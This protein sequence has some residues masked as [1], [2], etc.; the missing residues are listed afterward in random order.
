MKKNFKVLTEIEELGLTKEELLKYYKGLKKSFYLSMQSG[1]N[2]VKSK[3]EE[4][5]KNIDFK[6]IKE[7]IYEKENRCLG[8]LNRLYTSLTLSREEL[9]DFYENTRK[10]D[11]LTDRPIPLIRFTKT[12]H[13]II[14]GTLIVWR[15]LNNQKLEIINK[16]EK[17][18]IDKDPVIYV[19]THVGGKYDVSMF[20]E[21]IKSPYVLFAGDPEVMYRTF[22]GIMMRLNPSIFLNTNSKSDRAVG[23][24]MAVRILNLGYSFAIA[25]EGI[26]NASKKE[27]NVSKPVL[28]IYEG[29]TRIAFQTEIDIRVVGLERYS[30]T[31]FRVYIGER[32]SIK[33]YKFGYEDQ[34]EAKKIAKKALRDKMATTKLIIW[35]VAAKE[36]GLTKRKD[37]PDDYWEKYVDELR[38]EWTDKNGNPYYSDELIESRIFKDPNIIDEEDVFNFMPNLTKKIS[39]DDKRK[40]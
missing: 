28:D 23:E 16:D 20:T 7:N 38:Y 29:A 14:L 9:P 33:P 22:D 18:I 8:D 21:A 2:L 10:L 15:K 32:F 26:W 19:F 17:N 31:F 1:V 25:S 24:K 35:N 11:D 39:I 3:T 27:K 5:K 40:N 6:N 4:T 37:I 36:D 13:P 30:K 34:E 12:I